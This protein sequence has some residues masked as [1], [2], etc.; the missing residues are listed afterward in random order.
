M[1]TKKRVVGWEDVFSVYG[2]GLL[3]IQ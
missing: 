2:P 1:V 3:L